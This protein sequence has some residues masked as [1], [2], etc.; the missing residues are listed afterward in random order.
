MFT[1]LQPLTISSSKIPFSNNISPLT[2]EMRT[3][4]RVGGDARQVRQEIVTFKYDLHFS[5]RVVKPAQ[6]QLGAGLTH[7]IQYRVSYYA[8]QMASNL[9]GSNLKQVGRKRWILKYLLLQNDLTEEKGRDHI[10]RISLYETD[11]ETTHLC[12]QSK[13][14]ALLLKRV[15]RKSCGEK[16]TRIL[17][18]NCHEMSCKFVTQTFREDRS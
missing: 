7:R 14:Q 2:R 13:L 8:L 5:T 16:D 10:W 4:K 9:P 3:L 11:S 15:R 6:F 17:I 18:I 12:L 1:L